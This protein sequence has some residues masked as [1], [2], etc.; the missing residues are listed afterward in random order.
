[1]WLA[2]DVWV[3][4]ASIFNLCAISLDRYIA[5]TRPFRYPHLMSPMRSKVLVASVW[6]VSFVICLPPLIGWNEAGAGLVERFVHESP[7]GVNGSQRNHTSYH[8][9]GEEN[10]TE[11]ELPEC[12]MPVCRLT[13]EQGYVIYSALGSFWIP[14]WIMVFFYWR[15]Y[16]TAARTNVAMRRGVLTTRTGGLRSS[17]S[18]SSVTLR[19]HRGGGGVGGRKSPCNG[20][21]ASARLLTTVDTSRNGRSPR[22]SINSDIRDS[23]DVQYTQIP[24]RPVSNN[25]SGGGGKSGRRRKP[26]MLITF[27][28]SPQRTNLEL[29]HQDRSFSSTSLSVAPA[30][31]SSMGGTSPGRGCRTPDSLYGGRRSPDVVSRGRSTDSVYR[32]GI[33]RQDSRAEMDEPD[34]MR[35]EESCSGSEQRSSRIMGIGR[36][37]RLQVRNHIKRINKERKAAKTVGIIVG[38]FIMCWLPFFSCYLSGA[39]CVDCTHPLVFTV[40]FWLGYCNSAINP[41]IYALFSKDFR[42]AFQKLL[43]CHCSRQHRKRPRGLRSLLNSLRIQVSSK[44]SDSNSE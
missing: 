29:I 40:F 22:A 18:D 27:K 3:S 28:K 19:I 9:T 33:R 7:G 10:Q 31:P 25:H 23:R 32:S 6:I 20:D 44:G 41:C 38:C 5:I 13:S 16:L 42:Y 14:V 1:M 15:I 43:R 36:M 39:F 21:S 35:D 2:I 11:A 26:K 4:T 17:A 30:S 12:E 24:E 37:G 8:V 34:I